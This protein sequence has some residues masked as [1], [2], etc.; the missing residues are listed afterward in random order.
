[1]R[2]ARAQNNEALTD[3]ALGDTF[4]EICDSHDDYIWEVK[5][6]GTR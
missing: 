2:A 6:G 5:A 4:T 1:L 3:A